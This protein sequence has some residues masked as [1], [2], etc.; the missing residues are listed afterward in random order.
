MGFFFVVLCST[1]LFLIFWGFVPLFSPFFFL[2]LFFLFLYCHFLFSPLSPP[3]PPPKYISTKIVGLVLF[4]FS[5]E[6]E[7]KKKKK[8]RYSENGRR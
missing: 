7:E 8:R 1:K 3:I 5:G 4:D 2:V 6:K